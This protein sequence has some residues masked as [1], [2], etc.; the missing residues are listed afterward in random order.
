MPNRIK[1]RLRI[2]SCLGV[3]E[4]LEPRSML[5]TV[6]DL[7]RDGDVD[8]VSGDGWFENYDG[9]GNLTKHVLLVNDSVAQLADLNNDGLPDVVSSQGQLLQN[10][11]AG[12]FLAAGAIARDAAFARYTAFELGDEGNWG[13][14]AITQGDQ[15]A[16]LFTANAPG[17]Q[18][19]KSSVIALPVGFLGLADV[20]RDGDIDLLALRHRSLL[21]AL[22]GDLTP[23][24]LNLEIL[25]LLR[26]DDGHFSEETIAATGLEHAEWG[27]VVMAD[28]VTQ[29][30]VITDEQ[31][32]AIM[33]TERHSLRGGELADV[34]G[35]GFVDV[36]SRGGFQLDISVEWHRNLEGEGFSE[37]QFIGFSNDGAPFRLI[38]LDQDG[39]LDWLTED[40]PTNR[41]RLGINVDGAFR[42]AN[43][44]DLGFENPPRPDTAGDLNGDGI[45]DLVL[46]S[47][48][49]GYPNWIDG[50][51]GTL[52]EQIPEPLDPA[53]LIASLQLAIRTGNTSAAFDY[54][55][56]GF[57]NQLDLEYLVRVKIGTTFGDANLDGQFTSAD[58]VA[59][60]QAGEYDDGI[61][62]NSTW[63]TGDWNGDG[64]F[65]SSDLVYAFQFGGFEAA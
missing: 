18:F 56:D 34:N 27:S 62:G 7:D 49:N 9:A 55:Q 57:V 32:L 40:F 3:R 54:N 53:E 61:L 50:A 6:I 63:E 23:R 51:T 65:D 38:D 29:E 60:F 25:T 35:D 31:W 13:I 2:R 5:T 20:D 44:F 58:L 15:Q 28:P 10:V 22:E 24:R 17:F 8:L 12:E 1:Y 21:D 42:D 52:H 16:H 11:G 19:R 46:Q 30:I 48:T 64:E 59:V 43:S 14:A 37:P 47:S 41:A 45:F 39:D 4:S 33:L 26:N 36:I